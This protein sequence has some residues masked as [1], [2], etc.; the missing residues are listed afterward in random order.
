MTPN[1]Q[2]LP[3]FSPSK[4]GSYAAWRAAKLAALPKD[5]S[6]LVVGVADPLHPT[7]SELAALAQRIR[8]YNMAVFAAPPESCSKETLR[9]FCAHFGLLRLD[10][11]QLADDDGISPLAVA[12][13][14][15]RKRYIPYTDRP[16]A[17]HTDGY[18]NDAANQVRGLV[19]WCE[20]EAAEGGAN[21]L[22]DH[23]LAYIALRDRDPA[24]AEAL[25]RPDVFA[26]P[27]N[28]DAD[29]ATRDWRQGPVFSIDASG[30]LH[31]RYT[32]RTRS[33][34]WNAAPEIQA[35]KSA[36]EEI[37]KNPPF[38]LFIHT[39]SAGQ[40]LLSNNVL[41]TRTAFKDDPSRPRLLWRARFHDRISESPKP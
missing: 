9:S 7:G 39:L 4:P 26:I 6:A 5:V 17:W 12:P 29:M 36:L 27:P 24:L 20:R 38:G 28:D 19:L 8:L 30:H 35:A 33:I 31:M 16:I 32:A 3:P 22:L 34:E 25:M 1:S 40:G 37:L 13:E 15:T 21:A 2:S 41:H 23:E 18:Y 11:N 10:A 14:G